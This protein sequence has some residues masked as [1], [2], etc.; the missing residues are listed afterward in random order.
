MTEAIARRRA[1]VVRLRRDEGLTQAEIADRLGLSRSMVAR[2]LHA[3]GLRYHVPGAEEWRAEVV[4]LKGKGMKA[5]D[6]A[7]RLGCSVGVVVR[8]CQIAGVDGARPVRSPPC[9]HTVTCPTCGWQGGKDWASLT[10]RYIAVAVKTLKLASVEGADLV[11][12]VTEAASVEHHADPAL[13]RNRVRWLL[14]Q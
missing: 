8:D 2:D 9:V 5:R 6:I 3:S 4:R 1:E 12:V 7:E 14:A 13:V 11:D 10:E